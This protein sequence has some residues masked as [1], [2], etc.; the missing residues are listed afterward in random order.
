MPYSDILGQK[1]K[2]VL[3]PQTLKMIASFRVTNYSGKESTLGPLHLSGSLHPCDQEPNRI[4]G[5]IRLKIT[6]KKKAKFL[7]YHSVV[8][9]GKLCRIKSIS[10]TILADMH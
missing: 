4:F 9:S 3:K 5:I 1:E 7:F 6:K 10:V 8:S 2:N